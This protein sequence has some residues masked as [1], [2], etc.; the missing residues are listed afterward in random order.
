MSLLW[1]LPLLLRLQLLLLSTSL[2][3]RL[4][5]LNEGLMVPLLLLLLVESRLLLGVLDGLLLL[6]LS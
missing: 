2:G 4:R 1:L 6:L 5:T 3:L